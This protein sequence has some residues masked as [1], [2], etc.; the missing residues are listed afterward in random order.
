VP[1]G[2][3]IAILVPVVVAAHI[4]GRPLFRVLARS[5]SFDRIVTAVLV[6]SVVAGLL[7]AVL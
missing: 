6:V 3:Q 7:T 2:E 5:G 4:A 1:T